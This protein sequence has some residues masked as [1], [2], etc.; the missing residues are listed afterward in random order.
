MQQ[1]TVLL[2]VLPGHECY[3]INENELTKRKA[4]LIEISLDG[5]APAVF[6]SFSDEEINRVV[7]ASLIFDSAPGALD[8]LKNRW[9]RQEE[10]KSDIDV[11]Y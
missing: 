1:L 9:D 4:E 6:Y 3:F 8:D 5:Y 11:D 2:P 7:P 10:T